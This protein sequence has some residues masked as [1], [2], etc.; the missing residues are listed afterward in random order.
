MPL[1]QLNAVSTSPGLV[2]VLAFGLLHPALARSGG[3]VNYAI[4]YSYHLS[5]LISFQMP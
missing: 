5:F 1:Q 2:R 4:Q 3:S